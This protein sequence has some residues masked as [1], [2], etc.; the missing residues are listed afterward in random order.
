VPIGTNTWT[1]S[2]CSAG[3]GLAN[4]W[5]FSLTVLLGGPKCGVEGAFWLDGTL[6]GDTYSGTWYAEGVWA[7][8]LGQFDARRWPKQERSS[9]TIFESKFH[10]ALP[11]LQLQ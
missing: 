4:L 5:D 11:G 8:P 10:K 1:L 7:Y 6:I 9:Q 2:P 3:D